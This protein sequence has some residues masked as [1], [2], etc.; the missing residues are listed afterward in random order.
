MSVTGILSGVEKH[1]PFFP[2]KMKEYCITQEIHIL[3]VLII[4]LTIQWTYVNTLINNVDIYINMLA[5][6]T[7]KSKCIA[8]M[9]GSFIL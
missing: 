3:K 8:F 9:F 7:S 5:I 6:L 4:L 2:E 1:F